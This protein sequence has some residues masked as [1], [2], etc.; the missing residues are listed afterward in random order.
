VISKERVL[1]ER[2]ILQAML[3]FSEAALENHDLATSDLL[4]TAWA[5]ERPCVLE[6]DTQVRESA[7]RVVCAA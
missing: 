5:D 7:D 4:Q 3:T 2:E 1:Q 6:G